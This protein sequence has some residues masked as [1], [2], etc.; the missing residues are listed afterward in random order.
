MYTRF[1]SL[2]NEL[3]NM[4]AP[5]DANYK[6]KAVEERWGIFQKTIDYDKTADLILAEFDAF[7]KVIIEEYR[8]DTVIKNPYYYINLGTDLLESTSQS[9]PGKIKSFFTN[10]L[11]NQAIQAFEAAIDLEPKCSFTAHYNIIYALIKIAKG[12]YKQG[13]YKEKVKY[14]ARQVI[15]GVEKLIH[16]TESIT[17]LLT[18]SQK[19]KEMRESVELLNQLNTKIQALKM[20]AESAHKIIIDIEISQKLI[21]VGF[22][23]ALNSVHFNKLSQDKALQAVLEFKKPITLYFNNLSAHSDI[24]TSYQA[25][26]TISLV[27]KGADFSIE[28]DAIQDKSKLKSLLPINKD[29]KKEAETKAKKENEKAEKEAITAAEK[30]EKFQEKS[31]AFFNSIKK[32]ISTFFAP[33]THQYNKLIDHLYYQGVA[34]IPVSLKM[35]CKNISHAQTMLSEIEKHKAETEQR[36][37]L[38][39]NN[40]NEKFTKAILKSKNGSRVKIVKE[41]KHQSKIS[42]LSYTSKAI[43]EDFDENAIMVFENLTYDECEKLLKNLAEIFQGIEEMEDFWPFVTLKFLKLNQKTANALIDLGSAP[44]SLSFEDIDKNT[45]IKLIYLTE[46]DNQNAIFSIQRLTL[47]EAKLLISKADRTEQ[48]FHVSL[49]PIEDALPNLKQSKMELFEYQLSGFNYIF[50]IREKN[51]IPWRSFILLF[52]FGIAQLAAGIILTGVSYGFGTPFGIALIAEGIGDLVR[53]ASCLVT[54]EFSWG[55]YAIQ[56]TISLAISFTTASYAASQLTQYG[57]IG[58]ELLDDAAMQLAQN[59]MIVKQMM[60]DGYKVAARHIAATTTEI[61]CTKS[62]TLVIDSVS[63]YGLE[64][65][66]PKLTKNAHRELEKRILDGQWRRSFDRICAVDRFLEASTFSSRAILEA[67]KVI[68][69]MKLSVAALRMLSS[70]EFLEFE[71]RYS[72]ALLKI[73]AET[74][75]FSKLLYEKYRNKGTAIF[76]EIESQEICKILVQKKILSSEAT[77]NLQA[78]SSQKDAEKFEE[79]DLGVYNCYRNYVVGACQEFV[80][81]VD[82]DLT[83]DKISLCRKIAEMFSG[84]IFK[85]CE[86][87]V[88]VTKAGVTC[89]ASIGISAATN[90]IKEGG[91]VAIQ[92]EAFEKG[93]SQGLQIGMQDIKRGVGKKLIEAGADREQ[94]GLK[95]LGV[96]EGK[97]LH[98]KVPAIQKLT[99]EQAL[100]RLT[101]KSDHTQT[102]QT[103]KQRIV[104]NSEP[105]FPALGSSSAPTVDKLRQDLQKNVKEQMERFKRDHSGLVQKLQAHPTSISFTHSTDF[106][107]VFNITLT[108]IKEG[109]VK[110][111]TLS[112]ERLQKHKECLLQLVRQKAFKSFGDMYGKIL[113][114]EKKIIR[115][116]LGV[117][118]VEIKLYSSLH[119]MDTKV[120]NFTAHEKEIQNELTTVYIDCMENPSIGHALL[121]ERYKDFRHIEM[122][123]NLMFLVERV[124]IDLNKTLASIKECTMSSVD[125]IFDKAMTVADKVDLKGNIATVMTK[126]FENLENKNYSECGNLMRSGQMGEV[127][128]LVGTSIQGM[129]KAYS[130]GQMYHHRTQLVLAKLAEEVIKSQSSFQTQLLKLQETYATLTK[131]INQHYM[132]RQDD[133]A[134][135]IMDERK[136]LLEMVADGKIS[137]TRFKI[138]SDSIAHTQVQLRKTLEAYY[139]AAKHLVEANKIPPDFVTKCM[140][141]QQMIMDSI[142]GSINEITKQQSGAFKSLVDGTKDIVFK[143]IEQKAKSKAELETEPKAPGKGKEKEKG[144]ALPAPPKGAPVAFSGKGVKASKAAAPAEDDEENSADEA[145]EVEAEADV[146]VEAEPVVK[147]VV[148][149]RKLA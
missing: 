62:A 61:I 38:Y 136:G 87:A 67:K 89:A 21:D 91:Q 130:E 39:L 138:Y 134:K 119:S 66:K 35:R 77:I 10:S 98:D 81:L 93:E 24:W 72:D 92:K 122:I 45:A 57:A 111:Q 147:K 149:S 68:T 83:P 20:L 74:T 106:K 140:K 34:E 131:E 43:I 48:D 105:R 59:G 40:L 142:T 3:K 51:P 19:N 109:F 44:M 53:A 55:T 33:V 4:E 56:K 63:D 90:L 73:V 47:A 112:Y 23:D 133:I 54:R 14:H 141:A 100:T 148:K 75:D 46:K 88:H 69:S 2:L 145:A 70:E 84:E 144:K 1:C 80:Q 32:G 143:L 25:K 8:L 76:S 60:Q 9:Y 135:K 139:S 123:R 95:L 102:I 103:L 132:S 126:Y 27:E 104:Q 97:I 50:E 30:F 22:E 58:A 115:L 121:M 78:N 101:L 94:R 113:E 16:Q 42:S 29:L 125:V 65:L 127:G 28:F 71:Q 12:D 128:F 41:S 7:K 124:F 120:F 129:F 13:N 137:D 110:A 114:E 11:Y 117:I 82:D 99:S 116:Y 26:N 79:L 85:I 146:E 86:A 118:L 18:I 31:A 108:M 37:T 5:G 17:T 107:I 15:E 49:K 52:L 96:G 64:T 36:A 6:R